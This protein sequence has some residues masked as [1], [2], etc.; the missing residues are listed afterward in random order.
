MSLFKDVQCLMC[1]HCSYICEYCRKPC[2]TAC[3]KYDPDC[4]EDT[5]FPKGRNGGIRNHPK[6]I[7]DAKKQEHTEK[8]SKTKERCKK[9]I[10]FKEMNDEMSEELDRIKNLQIS[11]YQIIEKAKGIAAYHNLIL[12]HGVPNLG[13]GDCATESANDNYNLRDEF[14]PYRNIIYS[15]PQE[16][17]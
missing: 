4:E 17:R 3:S 1:D 7:L 14:H 10:S 12:N 15:T 13:N 6:C 16:L 5:D 8:R 2:C 11:V 9:V